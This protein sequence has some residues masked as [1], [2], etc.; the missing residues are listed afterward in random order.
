MFLDR[1]FADAGLP[2]NSF[3]GV[4]LKHK[5]QNFLFARRQAVQLLSCLT[6]SQQ[7]VRTKSLGRCTGNGEH[8]A[9]WSS[10][11]IQKYCPVNAGR[12]A[13]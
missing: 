9:N 1:F 10:A 7:Y 4:S 8:A 3:V 12:L 13:L 2:S 11:V 5:I 6:R